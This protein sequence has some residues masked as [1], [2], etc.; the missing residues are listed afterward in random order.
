MRAIGCLILVIILA[1][2]GC[3][4]SSTL[5]PRPDE[6]STATPPANVLLAC[7][8]KYEDG[9]IVRPGARH[10]VEVAA[11]APA[12]SAQAATYLAASSEAALALDAPAVALDRA[13]HDERLQVLLPV[14]GAIAGALVGASTHD[15]RA[16]ND[17]DAIVTV[18][19]VGALA[20]GAA[21]VL[22]ASF[23]GPAIDEL[24]ADDYRRAV[25]SFNRDLA[26][27]AKKRAPTHDLVVEGADARV[28]ALP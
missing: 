22:T 7:R 18:G 19:L 3:A 8:V 5:T 16:L 1:S 12:W 15:P 20:G 17:S 2:V 28:A 11:A 25:R 23:V 9:R 26:L 13:I 6:I 21:G 14:G 4:T 27:N 10:D 24:A